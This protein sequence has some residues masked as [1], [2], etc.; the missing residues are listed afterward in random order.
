MEVRCT[1]R[2]EYLEPAS[3]KGRMQC[4][5][6]IYPFHDGCIDDFAPIFKN[7]IEVG[8]FPHAVYVSS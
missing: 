8:L 1:Y 2:H 7:L 4:E 6:S 3:T 5:K